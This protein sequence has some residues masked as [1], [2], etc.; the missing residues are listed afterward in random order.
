MHFHSKDRMYGNINVSRSICMLNECQ[1]A[2][3]IKKEKGEKKK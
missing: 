1:L 2:A 3:R